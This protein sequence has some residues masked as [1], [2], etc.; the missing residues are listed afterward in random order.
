MFAEK[1]R[2][3]GLGAE[4]TQYIGVTQQLG[5]TKQ[6]AKIYGTKVTPEEIKK[7]TKAKIA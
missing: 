6:K 2:N 1:Q 4:T 5:A 3:T 7:Q